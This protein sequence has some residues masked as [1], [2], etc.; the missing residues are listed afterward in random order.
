MWLLTRAGIKIM[1]VKGATDI[2]WCLIMSFGLIIHQ[3][4]MASPHEWLKVRYVFPRHVVIMNYK[5]WK[6]VNS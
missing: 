6:Y 4:L 1:L 3:L 2:F 5:V